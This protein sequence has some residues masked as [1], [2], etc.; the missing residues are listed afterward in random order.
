MAKFSDKSLEFI[1]RHP[2]N[3]AFINILEG[4]VRSSK[5]WTMIPKTIFGLLR[6]QVPGDRIFFGKT[7]DTVYNNVLNQ[8][9]DFV[10]QDNYRYNRGNGELWLFGDRWNVVGAKDEG[11]E[12]YIRGRT[13]GL[14]YG[15]E[16]TLTPKSFMDMLLSRMSPDGAR[17][18]GTTNPDSPYHYLYTDYINDKNK[19]EKGIV[20]SISFNMD[21][22]L[23]LS[24]QKREQYKALYKGVFYERFILGKWVIAEGAIYKDVY[25]DDL[26]YDDFSRPVGLLNRGGHSRVFVPIDYGTANPTVFLA[27]FDDGETYWVEREYY[28]DSRETG[29]QKTDAEY[30]VDLLE[31][32]ND[33]APGAQCIV[34]PA[35]ASFKA[36]MIQKG[37]WHVN[38]KNEVLDGIRILSSVLGQKK[39][40]IHRRC[41]KLQSELQ[42]YAWDVK[43]QEKG[44]D[45]PIKAHD[46]S[47]DALRYFASTII[48]NWRIGE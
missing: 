5:T 9:F 1:K 38:A 17:F 39:I 48:P 22:N 27:I 25:N 35:A 6:Y 29:V 23:S 4:A 34:D 13:V 41:T 24:Q 45:K 46:H 33:Y 14:A 32:I 11:S 31:F 42:T 40:R 44:E 43:A 2:S 16:I 26:L 12:E 30:I 20:R 3:D 7:K 15:D 19:I 36:E 8:I 28:Y 18:Y 10:G 21:D 37:V 47:C